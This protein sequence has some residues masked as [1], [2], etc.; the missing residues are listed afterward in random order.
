[1]PEPLLKQ[2]ALIQ[3]CR[4]APISTFSLMLQPRDIDGIVA[5]ESQRTGDGRWKNSTSHGTPGC[6]LFES[7][8]RGRLETLR[9]DLFGKKAADWAQAQEKR[10]QM[11]QTTLDS[12]SP[13]ERQAAM[14]QMML[15]MRERF[16]KLHA[17]DSPLPE[18]AAPE[19]A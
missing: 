10:Q 17:A 5:L 1:L 8:D 3:P 12:I 15:Q 14:F 16:T 4:P 9:R 18:G 19:L 11:L 13:D 2:A 7:S 6:V